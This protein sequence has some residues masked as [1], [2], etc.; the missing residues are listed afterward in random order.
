MGNAEP[1]QPLDEA[2]DF[3][4]SPMFEEPAAADSL[5]VDLGAFEGPLDLLLKLAREQ[6]VDLA[7][8]SILALADQYLTYIQH[9]KKRELEIAADYLVM[10]AWLAYLKSRLLLP[11][12][13]K[14]EP[15][16]A[17]MAAALAFQLQRLQAMQEAGAR[18]FKLPQ[19]GYEFWAKGEATRMAERAANNNRSN[20]NINWEV[21]LY[22]LLSSMAEPIKR[23]QAQQ[24]YKIEPLN[25][26]SM[27]QAY[28]R[29]E[30]MLG[31]MPEWSDLQSFL[32]IVD[33]DADNITRRSALA[34][35]FCAT[36]EMAKLGQLELRQEKTYG[37]IFLRKKEGRP[38]IDM[39]EA[40]S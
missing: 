1:Q 29:L 5:V 15:D 11:R 27:E 17:A 12:P 3:I 18:L 16:P 40:T 31:V 39:D 32:V 20:T 22:E 23:N 24:V 7:Q 19:L 14:E 38:N 10:A 34:S 36:L 37:N 8:I 9:A 21:T 4:D 35:A 2:E 28:K 30:S 26:F 6:K 13:T 25:L 33:K